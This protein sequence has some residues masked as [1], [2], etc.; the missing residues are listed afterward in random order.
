MRLCVGVVWVLCG[1]CIVLWVSVGGVDVWLRSCCSV[2]VT[3]VKGRQ[4][5]LSLSLSFPHTFV[6]PVAVARNDVSFLRVGGLRVPL[7]ENNHR[8]RIRA[9]FVEASGFSLQCVGTNSGCSRRFAMQ[10]FSHYDTFILRLSYKKPFAFC[11]PG[12]KVPG[13][14]RTCNEKTSK[15]SNCRRRATAS[16]GMTRFL[17]RLYDQLSWQTSQHHRIYV[18]RRLS[19][20][21]VAPLFLLPVQERLWLVQSIP[22]SPSWSVRQSRSQSNQHN[23]VSAQ[24]ISPSIRLSS[25]PTTT[26]TSITRP[27]LP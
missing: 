4:P 6:A 14:N 9:G 24:P 16:T 23:V 10:Y 2:L 17:R 8:D 5:S 26:T 25:L 7:P 11:L 18:D 15:F 19:S 3:F 12:A 27:P 1:C 13:D 21:S 20:F 22:R